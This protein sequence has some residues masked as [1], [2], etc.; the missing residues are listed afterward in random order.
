[1]LPLCRTSLHNLLEA[2]TPPPAAVTR[3]LLHQLC[4][5]V[6]DLHAQGKEQR[7]TVISRESRGSVGAR[8]GH[9]RF[10]PSS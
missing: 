7:F 8:F 10:R 5:A 9:L 1:M 6:A 4:R 3:T 2:E